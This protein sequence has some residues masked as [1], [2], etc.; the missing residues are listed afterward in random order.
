MKYNKD[1]LHRL[2]EPRVIIVSDPL[3]LCSGDG[4]MVLVHRHG[5]LEGLGDLGCVNIVYHHHLVVNLEKN[6]NRA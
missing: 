4:V 5:S 1:H 3:L 6:V 2:K